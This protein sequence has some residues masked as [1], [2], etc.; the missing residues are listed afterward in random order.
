MSTFLTSPDQL[1][2]RLAVPGDIPACLLL[3]G[4]TREN[5][6]SAESLARRGIT[7]E[8]WANDVRTQALTGYVC[9]EA[10]TIAGYCFGDNATGEIVVLALLPEYE[11]MGAGRK[12]LDMVMKHLRGLGHERLFLGCEP[13]PA[14]R[15]HGFYRHLGWVPTGSLDSAGDE[16]LEHFPAAWSS[17]VNEIRIRPARPVDRL[18]LHRMLELY[19]YELSEIWDQDLD[20][21]GEYGYALDRYFGTPGCHAFVARSSGRLAGFALVDGAVKVGKS[22]QWMDQFFI[23]KKYRRA[24]LGAA[25]ARHAFDAVPGAW[26]VGQMPANHAAQAFWRRVIG[27]YTAGAY[28]EHT[29][30]RGAWR[31]M[32]QCFVTG[33]R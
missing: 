3:R 27:E 7:V 15:S 28:T 23:L 22:G 11:Y 2:F 32:V 5:A 6:I 14:V 20:A 26:E 13:D 19:Q 17:T 4:Q 9:T 1:C 16:V 18:V 31:G 8:S 33:P 24:G 25:L 10:E 29:V 30:I 12:L 21:L